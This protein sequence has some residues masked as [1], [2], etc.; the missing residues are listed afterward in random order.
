V[1]PLLLGLLC[2]IDCAGAMPINPRTPAENRRV[3]ERS[4]RPD[5]ASGRPVTD[6]TLNLREKYWQ[7]FIAWTTEN[8]YGFEQALELYHANIEE[9]NFV[10]VKYG[11]T[12][13]RA[14]KSYN[15]YAETINCLVSKK[16][17]LRR[18]MTAAWDLGFSWS[19]QEP[20]QQS[21]TDASAN[22]FEHAGY[23]TD[24]GL[25]ALLWYHR[26][27]LWRL[28][29]PWRTGG[30]QEG[31]PI[32]SHRHWFFCFLCFDEYQGT[33]VQVYICK[34]SIHKD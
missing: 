4:L 32:T 31:R 18:L 20:S 27:R 17:G 5:L 33:Q 3:F 26:F 6:A 14:G 19:K 2:S 1:L 12:L 10:L 7:A 9:I 22:S 16:P 24:V 29:P 15:Q 34:T 25:E 28:A 21:Y 8:G 13:Y 23:G 11:R 30:S